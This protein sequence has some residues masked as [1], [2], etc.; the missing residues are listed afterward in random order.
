MWLLIKRIRA[1]KYE[2]RLYKDRGTA[3]EFLKSIGAE[4]ASGDNFTAKEVRREGPWESTTY[5]EYKLEFL[6]FR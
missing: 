4:R 1:D 3:E 2:H 6:K 5:R